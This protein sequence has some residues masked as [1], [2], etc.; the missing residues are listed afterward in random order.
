MV[1]VIFR[2]RE[3][4]LAH[5]MAVRDAI[6]KAGLDPQAILA[7]RAGK[8]INEETITQNGDVIK[9]ITVVSGG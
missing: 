6:L 3:W 4:Q 1:T 2:D 9:L 7:M 5:G 8:L